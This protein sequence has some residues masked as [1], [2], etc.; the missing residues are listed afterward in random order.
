L[1][2]NWIIQQL[3][4]FILQSPTNST[5]P[6]VTLYVWSADKRNKREKYSSSLGHTAL[7]QQADGNFQLMMLTKHPNLPSHNLLLFINSTNSPNAAA[8]KE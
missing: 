2:Y 3:K 7:V 5:I 6:L 8:P 4:D 1:F